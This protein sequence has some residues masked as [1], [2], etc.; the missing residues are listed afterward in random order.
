MGTHSKHSHR[1]AIQLPCDA[2]TVVKSYR[3]PFLEWPSAT[4]SHFSEHPY[5][6]VNLPLQVRLYFW[7]QPTLTNKVDVLVKQQISFTTNCAPV[8]LQWTVLLSWWGKKVLSVRWDLLNTKVNVTLSI[9]LH[10]KLG[11]LFDF[12]HTRSHTCSTLSSGVHGFENHYFQHLLHSFDPLWTFHVTQNTGFLHSFC[13]ICFRQH[14]TCFNCTLSQFQ[15][16]L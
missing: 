11:W 9:F 8:Y 13:V 2:A 7:R 12:A 5:C 15:K 10:S 3:T 6:P 16:E 1:A 4:P 14:C